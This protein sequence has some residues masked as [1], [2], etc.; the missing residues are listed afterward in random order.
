MK[1]RRR[2]SKSSMIGSI[3]SSFS[4]ASL[5]LGSMVPNGCTATGRKKKGLKKNPFFLLWKLA[6]SSPNTFAYI[7][8]TRTSVK[9]TWKHS[10]YSRWYLL[11]LKIR[12][13]FQRKKYKLN[14]TSQLVSFDIC[15]HTN[16]FLTIFF[17]SPNILRTSFPSWAVVDS[18]GKESMNKYFKLCWLNGWVAATQLCYGNSRRQNVTEWTLFCPNKTLFPNSGNQLDWF[19]KLYLLF[20]SAFEAPESQWSPIRTE[21]KFDLFSIVSPGPRR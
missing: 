13:V 2:L 1:F 3:I 15:L 7:S 4:V 12:S 14:I 16:P 6:E 9:E 20:F 10:L 8:L 17:S 21:A 5:F 18:L 19:C 11:P